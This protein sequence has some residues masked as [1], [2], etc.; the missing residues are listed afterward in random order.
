MVILFP[1]EK[2][3]SELQYHFPPSHKDDPDQHSFPQVSTV[4]N[5]E[6]K[7]YISNEGY[8]KGV[9]MTDSEPEEKDPDQTA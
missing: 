3:G 6:S 5:S 1:D 8:M 9:V 7:N 4:S 2:N